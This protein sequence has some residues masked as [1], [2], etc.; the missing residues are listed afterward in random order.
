MQTTL[1]NIYFLEKPA[2]VLVGDGTYAI[3]P[4][5]DPRIVS[6]PYTVF[7]TNPNEATMKCMQKNGDDVKDIEPTQLCVICVPLS[8][9]VLG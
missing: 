3:D 2:A 6:G 8:N 9:I 7:G 5:L 4:K 1:F